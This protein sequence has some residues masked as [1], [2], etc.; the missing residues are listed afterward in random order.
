M[1]S[2]RFD[3]VAALGAATA[4]T[5]LVAAATGRRKLS[6]IAAAGT[7]AITA[8]AF[9]AQRDADDLDARTTTMT[10]QIHQ[11]EKAVAAQVQSRMTAEAAVK[12]LSEQLSASEKRTG[13]ISA[14]IIISDADAGAGDA[15][16]TDPLTGLF[17]HEYFLV[18]LDLR[19]AAARRHLRPVA[20]AFIQVVE[21]RE[22]A[23]RPLA[24]PILVADALRETLRES[25]SATRLSDGRFGVVLDD[26]PENGAIWTLERLRRCLAQ[27]H[28]T[29]T[30]WAGVACYP[31]HAFDLG[32]I[33]DRANVALATAQDW[34]QD[35]IEVAAA[36]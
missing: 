11:L 17:N 34:H 24:D 1:S 5:G 22:G 6:F 36:D 18:T 35:R 3:P 10:A 33:I 23:D 26:T 15:G 28:P 27:D 4:A 19:I 2:S 13:D 9:R 25:D 12:S 16:L 14:P 32:A 7:G 8:R 21:G 29:L 30:V 31:A 20:V